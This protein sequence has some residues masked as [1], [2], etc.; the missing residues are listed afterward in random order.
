MGQ[1]KTA[2]EIR[3]RTEKKLHNI[4]LEIN[5]ESVYHKYKKTIGIRELWNV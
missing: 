2:L 4:V 5:K 3:K 1:V